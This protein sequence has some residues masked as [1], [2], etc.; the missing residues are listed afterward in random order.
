MLSAVPSAVP[1]EAQGKSRMQ[2][3]RLWS[4]QVSSQV[5]RLSPGRALATTPLLLGCLL[6]TGR[7]DSA[8]GA[9]DATSFFFHIF[10]FSSFFSFFLFLAQLRIDS[11]LIRTTRSEIFFGP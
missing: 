1:V 4:R 8:L 6:L 5:I 11:G 9:P 10:F 3:L 2:D 7:F